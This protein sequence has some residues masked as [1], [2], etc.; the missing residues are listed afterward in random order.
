MKKVRFIVRIE[1][2]TPEGV[3]FDSWDVC[4]VKKFRNAN[5]LKI[6]KKDARMYFEVQ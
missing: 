4:E 1:Y 6:M 2:V 3:V 5:D